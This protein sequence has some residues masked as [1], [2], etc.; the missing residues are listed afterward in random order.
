MSGIF[1]VFSENDCAE[2]LFYGTDYNSHLGTEFA[3]MAVLGD[4]FSRVIHNIRQSQ[5]KSKFCNDYRQMRGN[6]GIGVISDCD[7][8]PIYLSSKFGPFCI[9]IS[10]YIENAKTLSDDLLRE[11]VSFSEVTRGQVNSTELV[12]KLI[13]Q[14]KDIVDGIKKMFDRIQGSCS[15]LILHKDGIYAARD[16]YGYMP[17]AVGRRGNDWA[18][19]SETFA[20]ENI[21]FDVV[22]YIAPGEIV[23][24]DGNGISIKRPAGGMNQICAFLWIYT[25]FPASNYEG[26]NTEIVRER[27][28]RLLAMRD[29]DIKPDLVTGVPDSGLSHGLGYAMESGLPFRRPLVK[30]TPGYGRSYTQSSQDTRN[31]VATMKLVAI[32]EIVEGNKIVLCEDSIVRGTQLRNF[33]IKKLWNRGAKE[34][35]ARLACPPLMFPCK[36]NLSTR[37][38]KELAARRAIHAL[39]GRDI[40]DVS[41]YIDDKSEKYKRMIEYIA[42]DLNVTTLR[43]QTIEDMVKAIGLD[44]EK[45][46]LYC[47]TGECPAQ[48]ACPLKKTRR[49]VAMA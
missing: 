23:L 4:D 20:F 12:A 39:E 40:E 32:R 14:G 42:K 6:K 15:L 10:G 26:I 9:V 1:G 36:F 30:Y 48:G 37:S 3:G 2:I 16:R 45:L 29:K 46:C 24:L 17:L 43:Y 21:G 49:Q 31:H 5:F 22:K 28:G 25:G 47:W 33:A 18:A 41:E 11:G 44:R 27:C 8:Q 7:E 34:I 35:H 38:I 13:H 19:A